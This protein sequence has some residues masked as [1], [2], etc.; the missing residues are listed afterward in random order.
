MTRFVVGVVVLGLLGS[1]L[2]GCEK[3]SAEK[4]G[5][6]IDSALDKIT[7]KGSVQ[8]IGKRIDKAFDELKK[9]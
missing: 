6:K 8:E 5:E 3:G 2:M 7:G 1:G 9:K 4:V